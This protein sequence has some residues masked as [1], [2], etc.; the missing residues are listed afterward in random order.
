ML[1]VT[2]SF[3][4][5]VR[6]TGLDFNA[7]SAELGISPTKTVKKGDMVSKA[8][9]K[10][11][12]CDSWIYEVMMQEDDE[13]DFDGLVHLL[14]ELLPNADFVKELQM[15]DNEVDVSCFV[16][17]DHAQIGFELSTEGIDLLKRL[18]LCLRFHILSFGG[19]EEQTE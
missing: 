14:Q 16:R 15:A 7:I 4:F 19:V 12:P 2:G 5:G 3:S 11:A 6:G 13:Y 10:C 17:S 8:L 9:N 1:N 18:G